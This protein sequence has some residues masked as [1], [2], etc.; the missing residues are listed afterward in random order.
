MDRWYR[1][2][3]RMCIWKQWKR[4]RTKGKML[5]KLGLNKWKAWEYANTRKSYWHTANSFILKRTI[6]IH[7]LRQA[8]Y[9]SLLDYYLKVRT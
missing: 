4:I 3:L 8:G 7:R 5:I 1:R 2:R 9:T 6:T